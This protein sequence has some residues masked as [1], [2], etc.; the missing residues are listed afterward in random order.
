M[1]RQILIEDCTECP[2]MS[3]ASRDA[4]CAGTVF[5]RKRNYR[6]IPGSSKVMPP[7]P[8]PSPVWCP[9]PLVAREAK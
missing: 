6:A 2:F 9:L 4:L 8:V 5:C 1:T 7:G 3:D